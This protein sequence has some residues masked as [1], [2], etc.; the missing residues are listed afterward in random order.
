MEIVEVKNKKQAKLFLDV[1]RIIYRDDD[2]WVCPLDAELESIFDPSRNVFFKH[3]DAT[4]WILYDSAGNAAGRVAAFI[5]ENT[6][7]QQD[8]PTGGMGFFECINDAKGAHL[9]FDTAR[10]WLKERGMEAM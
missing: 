2:T 5:D 6:A 8:R 1:A 7:G 4:R 9:L 3:G 10:D